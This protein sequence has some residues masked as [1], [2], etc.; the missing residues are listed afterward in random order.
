MANIDTM[1]QNRDEFVLDLQELLAK[2]DAEISVDEE[3]VKVM[4]NS[5][6]LDYLYFSYAD[7]TC[8]EGEE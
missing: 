6:E 4:F 7:Q 8:V 3:Q 2:H 5:G 1:N